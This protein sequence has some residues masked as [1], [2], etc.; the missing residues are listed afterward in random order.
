MDSRSRE[1]MGRVHAEA[2]RPSIPSGRCYQGKQERQ[3]ADGRTQR[4]T[5]TVSIGFG[6]VVNPPTLAALHD[7][8]G[9][10][11]RPGH[12][13]RVIKTAAERWQEIPRNQDLTT[14]ATA[15]KPSVSGPFPPQ[16]NAPTSHVRGSLPQEPRHRPRANTTHVSV[17]AALSAGGFSE[18]G[19]P[20]GLRQKP[21]TGQALRMSRASGERFLS[22]S[23]GV[24][25]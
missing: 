16:Q 19:I 12:D 22:A 25:T 15:F 3:K 17:K 7:T 4:R 23:A 20:Y 10:S 11:S 9:Q 8:L 14:R 6:R 2:A 21:Q 1:F 13:S 24:T 18:E 5:E